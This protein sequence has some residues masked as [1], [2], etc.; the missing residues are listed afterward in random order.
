VIILKA[1]VK[2][3]NNET[4]IINQDEALI[5]ILLVE[6]KGEKF[7]ST[8]QT[9]IIDRHMSNGLIPDLMTFF[10]QYDY[11]FLSSDPCVAYNTKMI[12]SIKSEE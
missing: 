4:L 6:N 1:I 2:F 12:V 11:F 3:S 9:Y 7:S 5:P 10:L 8:G